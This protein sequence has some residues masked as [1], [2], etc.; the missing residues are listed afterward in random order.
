M[1]DFGMKVSKDGFD[2]KT[3]SIKDLVLHSEHFG[4]KIGKVGSTT[5]SVTSGVGGSGTVA[6]GM[7]Y[8]PG[9]LAFIKFG[10]TKYFPPSSWNHEGN[11]EQFL[12][13]S[14]GTNLN[15]SVDSNA[16]SSY[17]A[18]VYYFILVDPAQPT[19]PASGVAATGDYGIK[20][21][22]PGI[23]VKTAKDTELVFSSKFN[24]FKVAETGTGSLTSDA[25]N[26]KTATIP[27]SLGYVP[28]FMVFSEIHAGFGNPSTGD[29]YMMP[30]SP[31]AS[32]GGSLVTDTLI[33]AID[34]S[35]LHIRMGSLFVAN[36]KVINYKYVIF[37]NQI[38]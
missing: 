31:P 14:D 13:S 20:I 22:K 12:A 7:G 23:D 9:F 21:S 11:Y 36:T 24:T 15:F 8:T 10:N 25:T 17:T 2:A 34:S 32:I 30:S 28:A 19:S 27:H 29:F 18:T 16:S 35:N 6:H 37:H 26:P 4:I 33:V 3:A 5:F 38:A 1:T